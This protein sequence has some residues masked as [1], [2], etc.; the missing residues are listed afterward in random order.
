MDSSIE[1]WSVS[2]VN[3]LFSR[4]PVMEHRQFLRS[5]YLITGLEGIE[6]TEFATKL[7]RNG[8]VLTSQNGYVTNKNSYDIVAANTDI[9][10][11]EHGSRRL[12]VLTP[13]QYFLDCMECFNI[14]LDLYPV[15]KDFHLK[16][17]LF[18][19]VFADM[20]KDRIYEIIKIPKGKELL[21]E[22]LLVKESAVYRGKI[23]AHIRDATKRIAIV[24]SE[25]S[26]KA[27]PHCGFSFICVSDY[28]DTKGFRIVERRKENLWKDA[29]IYRD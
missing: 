7:T 8:I 17:D 14:V 15:S 28:T 11:E 18:H 13:K 9:Q 19:I 5:L 3:D 20:E 24:D 16:R 6:L 26:A 4:L 10:M 12:D 23:G 2:E 1:R 27:I 29:I 22:S 25:I 21:Y